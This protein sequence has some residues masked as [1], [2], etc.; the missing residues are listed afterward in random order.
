MGLDCESCE[1][2]TYDFDKLLAHFDESGHNEFHLDSFH[3]E[4]SYIVKISK[5]RY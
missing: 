5:S 3:L 2:R 4:N 1:F